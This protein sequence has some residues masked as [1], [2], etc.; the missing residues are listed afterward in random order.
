MC[1]HV[2]HPQVTKWKGGIVI[3]DVA[4]R[5][6]FTVMTLRRKLQGGARQIY[7]DISGAKNPD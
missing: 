3:L 1:V 7:P 5:K 6:G 2:T 4:V